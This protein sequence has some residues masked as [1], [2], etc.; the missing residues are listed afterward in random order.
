MN[1]IKTNGDSIRAMTDEELAHFILNTIARIC[2]KVTKKSE[3]SIR[4][5]FVKANLYSDLVLWFREER[6]K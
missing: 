2:A 4:E 1:K 3:A 5:N 6:E